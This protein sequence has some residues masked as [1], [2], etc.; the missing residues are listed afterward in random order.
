MTGEARARRSAHRAT[1]P[2]CVLALA[3]LLSACGIGVDASPNVVNRKQVPFGLLRPS[4]HTSTPVVPGQYVTIY[5]EGPQRLV[6]ASREVAAPVSAARVL[7]ALGGGPTSAEAS[8]GL[9]S[10]I[11]T[12]APLSLWRLGTASVT[13]N[14]AG[15]FTKLAGAVQVV[16]VAQLVYTLTVLPG[17][18]SVSLRI[19]GKQ[20][21]V[22]TAKGTLTGGP[23]DRADYGTLAPI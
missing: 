7:A 12:A 3:L 20:A 21:K 19:D 5:L 22:P 1:L 6:A 8:E 17:V 4:T 10:P 16:A 14:V 11:S 13:V 23:L 9:E 18:R 15:A 2:L